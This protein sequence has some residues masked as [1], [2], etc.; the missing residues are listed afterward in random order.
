[1]P[2]SVRRVFKTKWFYKA[3]RKAGIV[4][5]ELC[6]AVREL[7]RGQG[8]DLDGNRRR[9]IVLGRIE[10]AWVFVFLFAKCDRDDIDERELRAFRQLAV[11]FG[12]RT[13][14]DLATL[15]ALDELVEICNG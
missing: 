11:D 7:T 10:Q 6:R 5:A 2:A 15:I 4:D 12:H 1:M 9:A 14:G 3:A 8:V 13:D